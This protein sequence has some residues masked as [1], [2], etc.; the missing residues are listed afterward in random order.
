MKQQR[1]VDAYEGNATEAAR[2]AGYKHP[3]KQG[4]KLLV[5]VGICEAIE[6]RHNPARQAR[7][8]DIQ[9]RQECLAEIAKDAPILCVE[10]GKKIEL[11]TKNGDRI[12]AV[13]VLNKMDA[14]YVQKHEVTTYK[15]MSEDEMEQEVIK[16]LEDRGYTVTKND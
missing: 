13:D 2:I 1:F 11:A 9:E 8:M 5:K 3:N 10:C 7:L 6:K 14:L 12:K 4:P 16:R 15:N